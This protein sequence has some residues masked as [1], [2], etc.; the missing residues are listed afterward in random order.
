M[1]RKS[2]FWEWKVVS[3]LDVPL[4]KVT[5]NNSTCSFG[6]L[7]GWFFDSIGMMVHEWV[8]CFIPLNC[9]VPRAR[10]LPSN[11]SVKCSQIVC[12]C[13]HLY[14]CLLRKYEL[15]NIFHHRWD[16]LLYG[17][18]STWIDE[19]CTYQPAREYF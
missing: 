6:F 7:E 12:N 3:S 14:V 10:I 11:W 19:N 5:Q 17:E 18:S 13:L 2:M 16:G 4:F 8:G 1:N 15:L 9:H